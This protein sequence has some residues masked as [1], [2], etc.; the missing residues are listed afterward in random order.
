MFAF[1]G[2]ASSDDVVA[3]DGCRFDVNIVRR[4]R[5]S[6][7]WNSDPTEV[8]RCSWFHKGNA[9]GRYIPYEEETA[10]KLEEEFKIAFTTATWNH[11]VSLE[12][13]ETVIFHGPDILVLFPQI[14]VP[15]AWGNT[16]VNKRSCFCF[17]NFRVVFNSRLKR[18]LE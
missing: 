11:K 1:S 10:S 15:D 3:T 9:D 6:V 5:N 18:V 4:Q 8:R 12:N 16:P 17:L 13:G 14:Q 2:N 7:Y